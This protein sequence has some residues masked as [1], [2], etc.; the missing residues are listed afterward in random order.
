MP[1]SLK[2]RIARDVDRAVRRGRNG[3]R[4]AAG[5]QRL[6]VGQTP[7]DVVWQRDKAQLWRYR[8]GEI[9]YR[10][11][12]VIVHSLVSRSYVLDL[13]PGNSL[14][15]FLQDAGFEIYLLDWGVA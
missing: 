3:L 9:A 4:Y 13:Y 15:Q 8:R 12:I 11:P 5:V 14:V 2:E 10:E 6:K 7:K 1:P